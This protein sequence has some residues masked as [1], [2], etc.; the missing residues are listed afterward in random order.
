MKT[1]GRVILLVVK[2]LAG[3]WLGSFLWMA[4]MFCFPHRG[5]SH[6]AQ[7]IALIGSHFLF[8]LPA[9]AL[10]IWLWASRRQPVFGVVLIASAL[11]CLWSFATLAGSG[12]YLRP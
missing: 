9:V 11:G 12:F 1:L 10:G 3:C 7:K 8:I 4:F 5:E 6:D 2:M